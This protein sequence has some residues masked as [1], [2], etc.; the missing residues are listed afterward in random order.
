MPERIST[1]AALPVGVTNAA[2][3]SGV[4]PNT[5]ITACFKSVVLPVPAYPASTKVC[6]VECKNQSSINFSAVIWSAVSSSCIRLL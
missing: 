1:V 2:L 3:K 6:R 5:F 4:S